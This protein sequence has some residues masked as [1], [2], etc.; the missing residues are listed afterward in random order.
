MII[1]S[2]CVSGWRCLLDETAAGPFGD[3]L[4]IL[5]AP[6]GTGKSTLFEALRRALLDGHRVTGRDIEAIRPWGR[7]LAPKVTVELAHAGMEYRI[8]KQYLDS[9]SALLERKEGGR[10]RRL[11]ESAAADDQV[12][13]LLTKNPPGR[14]LAR[15]ENWG[16]AQVLWAPQGTLSI[17]PISGDVVAAIHAMLGAQVSGGETG[18]IER[19]IEARYLQYFTAKGKL[20]TG[21]EAPAL[22]QLRERAA[23]AAETLQRAREQYAAYAD[24]ARRV[25]EL[26]ARRAQARRDA[27][28]ITRALQSAQA[29]AE[30]FRDLQSEKTQRTERVQ[31]AE[32]QYRAVKQ[33]IDLMLATAKELAEARNT[34][35]SLE[36]EAPLKVKEVQDYEKEAAGRKAAL[37]DA[38]K[39]R[40]QIDAAVELAAAARRF[41]ECRRDLQRLAELIE[42]I[43]AAEA[44]VVQCREQRN[45]VVAPDARTLKAIRKAIKDRDEAQLRVEAS[46]ITLEIVPKSELAAEVI[47]GETPGPLPAKTDAPVRVLGS[48]EVVVELIGVARLRACGPAGSVEEH[49][50]ARAVAEQRL[51]QLTAPF[52]VS[53]PDTLEALAERAK[54]R[55]ARLGEAEA[56]LR[57]L[58]AEGALED[59][60]RQRTALENMRNQHIGEHRDWDSAPPDAAALDRRADE[61]TKA[62]VA[63]VESCEE[64]WTK[65]Q[66]ALSAAVTQQNV[67]LERINDARKRLDVLEAKQMDLSRDGKA[68]AEHEAELQR[69]TMAWDAAKG[70]LA[71]IEKELDRFEADPVETVTR[72]KVQLDA[73]TQESGK[74]RD[75]EVREEG[76]LESLAANGPYSALTD[77]EEHQ[78]QLE[79]EL[80]REELRTEAIKLLYDTVSACRTEAVAAVSRPVE[81]AA[82]RLLQRIAGQRLGSVKVGESFE[83]SAVVPALLDQGVPLDNLSGGEQ[84]QL[85]LATRL[86]LAEVLGKEER[87]LVVLDDVLTATDAGRLARIMN[88]LEDAAERLQILVLTCHPERYRGL[89]HALFFDL[90][91]L[92]RS[93]RT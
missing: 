58:L 29:D 90:E 27:D 11:A 12:R 52:G 46:L 86:A 35:V 9:P 22:V 80:R 21:K 89:Q 13:E 91:E 31:A 75:Q 74:V 36:R 66:N 25:E 60:M 34:L 14:G 62:F 32:A 18:L 67:F 16:L 6:N 51:K 42:K 73:A 49:R 47:A 76:R 24:A 44:A 87:Q 33:H 78:F 63:R 64:A 93:S 41:N 54:E 55:D 39:G 37:E 72:L 19:R 61:M 45:A 48:P 77:A 23:A 40:E 50:E 65:A 17:G 10:F 38:R 56:A 84:E 43:R 57:A 69:V 1:R 28:E 85:Y 53:E 88:V 2:I 7:Q 79:Q 5:H 83:P 26:R 81:A 3:G 20:K 71:A 15:H 82:T 30:I 8:T 70:R 92:V 68:L 4:N 59:L